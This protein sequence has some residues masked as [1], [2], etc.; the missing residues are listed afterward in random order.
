[1]IIYKPAG[2]TSH[3]VVRDLRKV[4]HTRKVGHAGTLDP[5]ATGV[6]VIGVNSATRMLGHLTLTTK[7]YQATIRLGASSTTDD[8]EGELSSIAGT[9]LISDT[10]IERECGR[11]VGVIQQVPS[12][13][14][15]V[16]VN[17]RRA[18]ER[19]RAGEKFEL[20]ART[21]EVSSL[22][23]GQIRRDPPWT[24]LDVII[25]CSSGTYVRAIARDVGRE[26]GVGAHLTKL[27]RLRVGPFTKNTAVS[28][29]EIKNC[30]DPWSY[31]ETMGEVA[32]RVWPHITVDSDTEHRVGRGQRLTS[33]GLPNEPIFAIVNEQGELLA[34]ASNDQ[35]RMSYR[36]VFVGSP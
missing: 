22:E 7:V 12:L 35:D 20:D 17:G 30:E 29:E 27:E 16:K 13:V 3:D 4:F 19:I 34:L 11:Q 24:D 25:E 8:A 9:E 1:M 36:A 26:L 23:I 14:S 15:A 2:V 5:M 28:L 31:V 10:D 33:Q 21:V 18:H 32:K 6:L